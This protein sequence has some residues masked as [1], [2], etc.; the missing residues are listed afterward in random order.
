VNKTKKLAALF[1]LMGV[2]LLGAAAALTVSAL[3]APV[4]LVMADTTAQEC[5]E[6]FMETLAGAAPAAVE[7]GIY[8]NPDLPS[9][10]EMDS[11]LESLLWDAYESSIAYTFCGEC[12]A[13]D[14][15]ICRD[16]EVTVLDIS[17]LLAEIKAQAH[18]MMEERVVVTDQETVFDETGHYRETFAMDVLLDCAKERLKAGAPTKRVSLTLELVCREGCWYVLPNKGLVDLLS[19][20]MGA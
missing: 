11:E 5:T 13:T 16:V 15:G 1:A 12:Y 3:D 17:G 6:A 9:A 20:S 7:A 2:L 14:S 4:R 10:D 8:G 18:P 19:G